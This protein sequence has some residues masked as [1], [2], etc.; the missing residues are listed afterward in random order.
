[1]YKTLANCKLVSLEAKLS[2]DA[3]N[4]YLKNTLKGVIPD[5]YK[6]TEDRI[7]ILND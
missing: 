5:R 2:R 7:T 1:M 3:L 6:S 4:D